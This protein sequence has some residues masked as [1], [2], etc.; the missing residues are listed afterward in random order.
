MGRSSLL[1][2]VVAVA[3]ILGGQ[4]IEGGHVKSLLQPAALLIVLSGT[5]GAVILQYGVANVVAGLKM[6]KWIAAG[7]GPTPHALVRDVLTWSAAAR[8]DGVLELDKF[9]PMAKDPFLAKG[10]QM[11]ADG[12][13]ADKVRS[14]YQ[15]ELA[16]QD[17]RLRQAAKTWDAAGGYAPTIGILGAV[18]GLIQ[19]ME[20]L[21]DPSRLG[22]GI[23]VAF[24]A[25]VYGVG[26]A[27]L[28]FLPIGSHLKTL[29]GYELTRL[30]MLADAFA[31]IAN[32]DHPRHIEERMLAYLK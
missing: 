16:V 26:F 18:L 17:A 27:N 23:A 8:K 28:V 29:V 31:C 10:L 13:T 19:V 5:L 21:T 3:G 4:V 25:T 9:I 32:N 20:N 24:V 7:R 1:G 2:L 15:I 11:V 6:A 22:S 30:E 14:Y 12:Y